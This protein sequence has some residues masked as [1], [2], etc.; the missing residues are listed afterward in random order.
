[1]SGVTTPTPIT[2]RYSLVI[3]PNTKKTTKKNNEKKQRKKQRKKQQKTTK[4][5]KP[6]QKGLF[7]YIKY[8]KSICECLYVIIL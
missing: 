7:F 1:M 8:L 4:N 3:N 5:N 6:P 2:I